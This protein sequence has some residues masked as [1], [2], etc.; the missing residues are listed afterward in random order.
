M[1][2]S[3]DSTFK[4]WS[5]ADNLTSLPQWKY[6][7]NYRLVRGLSFDWCISSR[8]FFI[9]EKSNTAERFSSKWQQASLL[10]SA[11]SC[12][13][14]TIYD[15]YM[16]RQA[17]DKLDHP[18]KPLISSHF[19]KG[20]FSLLPNMDLLRWQIRTVWIPWKPHD[21]ENYRKSSRSD[22]YRILS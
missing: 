3:R 12:V 8:K 21:D 2:S 5:L 4:T 1:T 20:F 6:L 17:T 18:K 19:P 16:I 13:H 15:P 22:N 10:T 14:C 7:G 9:R 11:S